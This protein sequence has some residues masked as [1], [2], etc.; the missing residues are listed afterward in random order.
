MERA[1]GY[2]LEE[3][4]YRK[5]RNELSILDAIQLTQHLLK[6]IKHIHSK[7]TFYGNLK[8]NHIMI[9]WDFKKL[10]IE[11]AQLTLIDFSQAYTTADKIDPT[12]Y[13]LNQFWYQPLSV[14]AKEFPC[15]STVDASS[16]CAILLWLITKIAPQHEYGKL[17][18]QQDDAE[19]EIERKINQEV[20]I[21]SK[22]FCLKIDRIFLSCFS[23][24]HRRKQIDRSRTIKN[25]FDRYIQYR[26]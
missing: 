26:F 4:I 23:V 5:Y 14:Y 24:R 3:F 17:P 19:A 13:Q 9:D 11:Q 16:I 18:H 10:P 25:V 1:P 12:N 15:S 21:G 8:P 6:I 2:T 22:F 7:G 20:E